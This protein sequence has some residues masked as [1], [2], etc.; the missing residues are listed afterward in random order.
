MALFD[1]VSFLPQC[2]HIVSGSSDSTVRVW[3][4][5]TGAN[6]STL[7]GHSNDVNSVA[8]SPDGKHIVSGSSDSTVR[9][10]DAATG[11]KKRKIDG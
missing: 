2:K 10:W 1:F 3:D 4:A 6:T 9:V 5:A 8:F 7:E 11:A